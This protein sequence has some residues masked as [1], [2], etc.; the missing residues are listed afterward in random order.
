MDR[1]NINEGLNNITNMY[2]KLTYF[3][4]YGS[5]VISF[6]II[7]IIILLICAYCYAKTNIQP[8][9]NDWPNQRCKPYYIPFAGFITKPENLTATEYTLENFNYCT[10]NILTSITGDMLMP[11]T[12]IT[13]TMNGIL[14]GATGDINSARAM[15][16]KVRTFFQTVSQEIMGRLMNIMI[17]LQK[18]IISFRDMVGKIQGTMTAGLFTLLGS[19]YTLQSLMGSIAEFIIIILIAMAAMIVVF[20]LIPF[21]WGAA[22]SMTSIFVAI[23]I[24]LAI[25]LT[26]MMDVLNVQPDLSIPTLKCFDKNTIL[27]MK[28]GRKKKISDICVGDDLYYDGFVNSVIKVDTKGSIM[29]N[30]NNTIVSDTHLVLYKDKWIRVKDHPDAIK[31][32]DYTEPYLYCLNTQTKTI[33]INSNLFSDWDELVGEQLTKILKTAYS[34]KINSNEI[35]HFLDSGFDGSTKIKLQNGDVKEIKCIEVGDRLVNN[36]LVYG[37]VEIDGST[38]RN[39]Y[40]YILGKNN[41]IKGSQNIN[42]YDE[43]KNIVSTMALD[44]IKYKKLLKNKKEKLYHLITDTK[45]FYINKI[46]FCHYNTTIDLFLEKL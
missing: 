40:E 6:I 18:I 26:F 11:L 27:L 20:W 37:I 22:I 39:Q 30:L 19:Y 10:Q 17:P 32:D 45:T 31:I 8:I 15:F 1:S 44:E 41:F 2:E 23:S 24:P 35:H 13:N 29:Y 3:D 25:M 9:I 5:S 7:T 33:F 42:Y 4:Q 43:N 34:K 46:Q 38:I 28:D 16:N 36:E 12:F 14:A 21:T